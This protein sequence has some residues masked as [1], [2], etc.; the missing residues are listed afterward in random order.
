MDNPHHQPN[1][2]DASPADHERVKI[3]DY[4][5]PLNGPAIAPTTSGITTNETKVEP[6]NTLPIQASDRADVMMQLLS[7]LGFLCSVG[8]VGGILGE[9][10]SLL[11][12]TGRADLLGVLASSTGIALFITSIIGFLICFGVILRFRSKVSLR[13]TPLRAWAGLVISGVVIIVSWITYLSVL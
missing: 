10:F 6:T 2:S 11:T 5:G 12:L 1:N 4:R 13:S 7:W 9:F 8:S 3:D